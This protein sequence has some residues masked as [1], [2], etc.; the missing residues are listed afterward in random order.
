MISTGEL[1]RLRNTKEVHTFTFGDE[2]VRGHV[3]DY[4]V[5][6]NDPFYSDGTVFVIISTA[7]GM[8]R[9]PAKHLEKS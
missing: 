7:M 8:R 1:E 5:V 6:D 2:S 3:E 4:R 9:F